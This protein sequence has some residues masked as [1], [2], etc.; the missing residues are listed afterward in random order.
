MITAVPAPRWSPFIKST[1]SSDSSCVEVSFATTGDVRLRDS[2]SRG[3]G[4][5]LLFNRQE[6]SA[7]LSGVRAGEFE[8]PP[9]TAG[10]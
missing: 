4:P 1:F 6:W 8:P 7:F 5:E 10:E 3:K 9:T 2:K